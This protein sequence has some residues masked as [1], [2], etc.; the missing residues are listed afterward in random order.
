MAASNPNAFNDFAPDP[1]NFFTKFSKALHK[2]RI[3][4]IILATLLMLII[5]LLPSKSK[6]AK[7]NG[8]EFSK[9]EDIIRIPFDTIKDKQYLFLTKKKTIEGMPPA[10]DQR[11]QGSC[12]P[13][14]LGY[15]LMSYYEKRRRGY[16]YLIVNNIANSG[17]VFSPAF[18]YYAVKDAQNSG[19]CSSGIDFASTFNFINKYGAC[20]WREFPYS[21]EGDICG[22]PPV[23]AQYTN[24]SLQSG[25]VFYRIDRDITTMKSYLMSEIPIIVGLYASKKMDVD[26]YHH[27]LQD[28]HFFWNPSN[29]DIDGYHAILCVGFDE[30][31]QCFILLNSWGFN[32]GEQGYCYIPYKTFYERARELYIAKIKRNS[33]LI[34]E[35]FNNDF[36]RKLSDKLADS[37]SNDP[38]KLKRY[39]DETDSLFKKDLYR[40]RSK[41]PKSQDDIL[42]LQKIEKYFAGSQIK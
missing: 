22:R 35:N 18:I 39:N 34:G 30:N 5:L 32:W 27:N 42:L 8:L 16:S 3:I 4:I 26:G 17:R 37:V 31:L 36:N 29:D 41:N 24:A 28:G 19:D 40:L 6:R 21:G 20:T 1:K 11:D 33:G 2:Y 38:L 12:V 7:K 25:Y 13:F 14:S 10:S 9:R 15:Y 23:Q